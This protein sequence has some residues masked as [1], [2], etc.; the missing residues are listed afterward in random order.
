[1]CRM[2]AAATLC[3]VLAPA[4]ALASQQG[5]VAIKNWKRMDA[6]ARQAQAAHPD[7]TAASNA[8]R[9]AALKTC[10]ENGNLPPRQPLSPPAR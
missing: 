4:L 7:Y 1:M 8:A 5:T 9:A 3:L 2:I 10:L 6:C